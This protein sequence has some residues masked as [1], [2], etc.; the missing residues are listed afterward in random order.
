[1]WLLNKTC[2]NSMVS[3]KQLK[4]K[5]EEC[6]ALPINLFLLYIRKLIMQSESLYI[7]DNCVR[8]LSNWHYHRYYLYEWQKESYNERCWVNCVWQNFTI[9]IFA[10]TFKLSVDNDNA[11][12]FT[13]TNIM[14]QYL[15]LI[16]KLEQSAPFSSSCLKRKLVSQL[17]KI[18]CMTYSVTVCV[19]GKLL[20]WFQL[21]LKLHLSFILRL[22]QRGLSNFVQ[23]SFCFCCSLLVQT[24][25]DVHEPFS[26]CVFWGLFEEKA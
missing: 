4:E 8:V 26:I 14:C 7:H 13:H 25:F 11:L 16:S 19:E 18:T 2:I 1:M 10:W 21:W 17:D 5:I 6:V 9:R 20:S 15:D 3:I 12:S 22:F 23:T 24:C